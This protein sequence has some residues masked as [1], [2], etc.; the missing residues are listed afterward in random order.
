MISWWLQF[1]YFQVFSL[2][3]NSSHCPYQKL[4]KVQK[5]WIFYRIWSL[6]WEQYVKIW[7]VLAR[8]KIDIIYL[9]TNFSQ[10]KI[11]EYDLCQKSI[12]ILN[13]YQRLWN[14]SFHEYYYNS[15]HWTC[16]ICQLSCE[17]RNLKINLEFYCNCGR[18]PSTVVIT[19]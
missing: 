8:F 13:R 6:N 12:I 18:K 9:M 3:V 14:Y 1:V 15:L 7:Y 2:P 4:Q 11:R 16:C 19:K 5:R 17:K 10:H